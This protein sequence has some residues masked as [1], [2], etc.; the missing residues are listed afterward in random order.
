MDSYTP[1]TLPY[2]APASRLPAPLP[3]QTEVL[4]SKDFLQQPQ[5]FKDTRIVR[6][7]EYFVA[8]YGADVKAVEGENMLFV[9]EHTNIPVPQVYAI[10][11]FDEGKTMLIMEYI[12]GTSLKACM[13]TPGYGLTPVF[14][15]LKAQVGELRRIPAGDYFGSIGRRPFTDAYS[16]I[17]YGPF[18]N[19]KEVLCAIFDGMMPPRSGQR[20]TN[21]RSFFLNTLQTL[22]SSRGLIHPVFTHGDLHEENIIVRP[23][24]TPIIIDYEA[25]GFYPAYHE[26]LSAVE[27]GEQYNLVD[28]FPEE[29]QLIDDTTRA[30]DKALLDEMASDQFNGFSEEQWKL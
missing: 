10:Y 3:T 26:Y 1:I 25:A 8:K 20:F 7:G 18:D 5:S 19:I 23:D 9:K 27:L 29:K 12:A 22:T 15:Q 21:I 17:T 4:A 11:T 16:L 14:D 13:E 30:W 2:I 6:V 28:P 24:G